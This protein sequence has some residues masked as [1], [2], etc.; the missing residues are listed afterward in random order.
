VVRAYRHP[1]VSLLWGGCLVMV[2][3]GLV[4]LSDRRYRLGVAAKRAAPA[5]ET[6]APSAGVAAE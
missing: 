4:S 5:P 6:P 3:G 1:W 2:I